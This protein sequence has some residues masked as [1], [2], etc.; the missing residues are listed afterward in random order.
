LRRR[1]VVTV[2]SGASTGPAK[3]RTANC[4][5]PKHEVSDLESGKVLESK[6]TQV[7]DFIED[8]TGMD[9]A[10]HPLHAACAGRVCRVSKGLSR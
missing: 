10:L 3:G 4:N 9:L 1:K 7:G 6:I 2:V 5:R 8:A